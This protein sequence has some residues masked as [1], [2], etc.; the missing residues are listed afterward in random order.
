MDKPLTDKN[1][2]E[3]GPG[4]DTAAKAGQAEDKTAPD[5]ESV[6]SSLQ[7]SSPAMGAYG[8]QAARSLITKKDFDE[9]LPEKE[10]GAAWDAT[11]ERRLAIR[12]VTRGILGVSAFVVAG[13]LRH[14]WLKGYN[15]ELSFA[16]QDN[17]LKFVSK[18]LDTVIATPI[19]ATVKAITGSEEAA[20]KAVHFRPTNPDWQNAIAPGRSYG[21]E[22]SAVTFDFFSMSVVDRLGR[23]AFRALDPHIEKPW[24]D[25]DGHIKPME[26][27]KSL[28]KELWTAVTYSGGEDWYAGL[29]YVYALR[30][31]KSGINKAS[32]GFKYDS[33]KFLNGSSFKVNSANKI[34]GN[35][36]NEG[37][38]DLQMRFMWYNGVT[39]LPLGTIHFREAY[40]YIGHKLMGKQVSLY[41]GPEEEKN[42]KDLGPVGHLTNIAKW[43][44]RGMVKS[45]ITM[46]PAVPFFWAFRT[47]ATRIDPNFIH[48]EKGFIPPEQVAGVGV[49]FDPYAKNYGVLDKALN[50]IGKTSRFVSKDVLQ[51]V[52]ELADRHA[53]QISNT[54][55]NTFGFTGGARAFKRDFV[56]GFG[57]LPYMYMKGEAA[58][59]G[60]DLGHGVKLGGWDNGKMDMAAERMIDGAFKF[61][62]RE[63]KAGAQEVWYATQHKE[64]PDPKR[65]EEAQYRI[66]TDETPADIFEADAEKAPLDHVQHSQLRSSKSRSPK[67]AQSPQLGWEER[68]FGKP[69]GSDG[70]S[71]EDKYK[72]EK[73]QPQPITLAEREKMRKALVELDPPTNA[74]N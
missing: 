53:P 47:P 33:D 26:A 73:P 37:A 14:K 48:P 69:K 56:R 72:T 40:D 15:S 63:F 23:S 58:G 36:T 59:G 55:N 21:A 30:A 49:N 46:T 57:Y 3:S 29:T 74:I 20:L 13:K 35:Y 61:D 28:G 1:K 34:V 25:K 7:A 54:L 39:P 31:I 18:L 11:P 41:G 19:K 9:L 66:L 44:L 70:A 6:S 38:L 8:P 10:R 32:P 62:W 52:V 2:V 65:E 12:T 24:Q 60:F 4:R 17:P 51:P 45:I 43:S 71:L 50:P 27:A 42:Y 5:S 67:P 22:V 68:L 16:E 64:L